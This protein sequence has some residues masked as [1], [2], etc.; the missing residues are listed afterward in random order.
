MN[1]DPTSRSEAIGS[2]A[3]PNTIDT[4]IRAVLAEYGRLTASPETLDADMDLYQVGMTSHASV[5]VL[6]GLEAEFDIEF[7]DAML[8]RSGFSSIAAIRAAL[9]TLCTA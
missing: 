5:N 8:T 4:R 6:I 9:L 1:L 2:P 3:G 7:P